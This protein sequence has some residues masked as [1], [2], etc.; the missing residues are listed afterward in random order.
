MRA[1]LLALIS[2]ASL[3]VC[4][5]DDAIQVT[6]DGRWSGTAPDGT[7]ISYEFDRAGAVTWFV[8]EPNFKQAFPQGLHGKYS[9]RVGAAPWQMDIGSFDDP[10]FKG[11]TFQ[12]IVEIIDAQSF[13][14]E[15]RPD[16]RIDKFSKEAVVF[17]AESK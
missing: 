3:N 9:I 12:G 4:A 7:K 16:Q 13:R 2:I 10:R 15:G 6:L 14:F 11:V 5:A 8:A 17:R 1:C